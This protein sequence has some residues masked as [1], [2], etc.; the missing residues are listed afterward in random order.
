MRI[1]LIYVIISLLI[2]SNLFS[3]D[4]LLNYHIR[5]YKGNRPKIGLVLSGGGAK[6][7]AH[8]GVLR[9]LDSLGIKPD[10]IT[11]TSMGSIVGGLYSIGYSTDMLQE[12]VKTTDWS[13]YLSNDSEYKSINMIEKESYKNYFEFPFYNWLPGLPQGAIKGQELELLFN[14]LTVSVAQDTVF[15][16]FPIPFRAVAVDI[17]TGKPYVFKS[18]NLALAMRSS[19]SIPSIM[20]PVKYK[21]MLL[22]DGGLV[23]N[24]PVQTCIDMGADIIIGVYTGAELMPEEKLN[25][26]IGILKQSSFVASIKKA[27]ASK[28]LVDIYI[29]PYLSDRNAAVFDDGV[30]N[31]VRGYEAGMKAVPALE[32][33][34]S[35]LSKFDTPKET[36]LVLSDSVFI[37][38]SDVEYKD[39]NNK[40]DK[41]VKKNYEQINNEFVTPKQIVDNIHLLYGTRLFNKLTYDYSHPTDSIVNLKYSVVANKDK[42]LLLSLNYKTESKAGLN[43]GFRYRNLLI[44]GSRFQV[45]FRL[46]ENPGVKVDVFSYLNS[47]INHGID[48]SYYY[49]TSK[50]PFYN[51]KKLEAEYS[52]HFHRWSSRYYYFMNSYS[53]LYVGI[54]HERVYYTKI[55]DL[56][57]ISYEKII[58]LNAYIDFGYEKNTLDKKYFSTKGVNFKIDNRIFLKNTF[59]Y[60]LPQEYI[61]KH[62]DESISE[63]DDM[64][65]SYRIALSYKTFRP[66]TKKIVSINE[67]NTV[68]GL[69]YMFSSWLG[70][71]NPEEEYQIP[72]WGV[73]ENYSM[74]ANVLVY[75]Y[76]LR[77]NFINNFYLT[78]K[79]NGGFVADDLFYLL[80]SADDN[81]G[82]YSS[83]Y[84]PD[85][86]L[87]GGG[88]ELSYSSF[89]GPISIAVTKGSQSSAFWWHIRLGYSF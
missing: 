62:P 89:I 21:G 15:D 5:E 86:Y 65:V 40:L 68:L 2:V 52:S 43:I 72:F 87:I 85:N 49:K 16:D 46:S 25:S 4:S 48:V 8:V 35:Y 81:E 32:E 51:D 7:M 14:K 33:L 27:N 82:E 9:V 73:S 10:F 60:D 56:S 50:I 41:I 57:S 17:L 84:N 61:D 69:G 26:M 1:R 88:L 77:Y 66:I 34:V 54:G 64:G 79:I 30:A 78:G 36:V 47:N 55:I 6:G 76:G 20:D 71:V 70:G 42:E 31:V 75:R 11:G 29:E 22:V 58:N 38:T 28:K 53:E 24:F 19:M 37:S 39:G 44:S 23:D 74:V 59:K 63:T 18:G 67:V 45:K 3:Q 13:K 80:S 83:I 12:M